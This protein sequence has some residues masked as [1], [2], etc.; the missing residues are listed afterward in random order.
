MKWITILLVFFTFIDVIISQP[1][2]ENCP[3]GMEHLWKFDE[4]SGPPYIDSYGSSDGISSSPPTQTLG[5]VNNAQYFNGVNVSGNVVDVPPDSSFDW[6]P[7][8]SFTIEYWMKSN[9]TVNAGNRVIIGRDDPSTYLQWWSGHT[10][11]GIPAFYLISTTKVNGEKE[12]VN[13]SGSF[14]ILDDNWHHIAVMRNGVND[15]LYLYVD[16][17]LEDSKYFDYQYGFDSATRNLNIGYLD[18]INGFRYKGNLDEIA[19]YNRALSATE[20]Q[21]HYGNG[22]ANKGYCDTTI[23]IF[24]HS[25]IVNNNDTITLNVIANSMPG[26]FSSSVTIE[27]DNTL[28]Q[29][30]EV[31]N[32]S[33]LES[34]VGAYS[35]SYNSDTGSVSIIDTI[36]V[37]E[38]I[39]GPSSVSGTG[40]LFNLVLLPLRSGIGDIKFRSYSL[41][42]SNSLAISADSINAEIEIT[43]PAPKIKVFLQGP[44]RDSVMTTTLAGLGYVP[45]SQPY[46]V[47]PWNYSGFEKVPSGF[48]TSHPDIVD[49]VLIELR[50]SETENTTVAKRAAF[51]NK[52]GTLVEIDG[53]SPISFFVDSTIQYFVVIRHRNHLDIMSDNPVGVNVASSLYDFTLAQTQA[54]TTTPSDEPMIDLGGGVFGMYSGDT[55]TS[56]II[57]AADKSPVNS[58]NLSVGYYNADTNF[59]GIVTAADKSFVN[60][61]NLK[62]IFVP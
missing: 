2:I 34:N 27:F 15:S 35:V 60:S 11:A 8:D 5:I 30:V 59:S 19:L 58:F 22:F 47:A 36:I 41:L 12:I 50:T 18:F 42:D 37:D 55:N 6:G 54:Y 32:G 51:L 45:L 7:D 3:S 33:F 13:M 14:S 62:A 38:E 16:G 40:V 4:T 28:F 21:A 26:L 9:S 43:S 57:T 23:Q 24:P 1:G 61:N 31:T 49:W 52:N 44:Y 20:V 39:L 10:A 46:D 48:F 53:V 29:F 17:V 25:Q 56:G